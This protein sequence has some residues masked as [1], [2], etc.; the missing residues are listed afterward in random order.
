M[1]PPVIDQVARPAESRPLDPA[2]LRIIEALAR[3][4][5]DRDYAAAQEAAHDQ[6]RYLQSPG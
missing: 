3:A 6:A 2:I 1:N 5:V 4:D